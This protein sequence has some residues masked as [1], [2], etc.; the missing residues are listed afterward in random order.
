MRYAN[1][2]AAAFDAGR[3]D[4]ARATWEGLP[5]SA[6]MVVEDGAVVAWGDMGRR[7]L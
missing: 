1:L 6:F 4:A 5:S 3:L 7:F 2:E